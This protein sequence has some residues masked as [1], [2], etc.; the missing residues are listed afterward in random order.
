MKANGELK[1]EKGVPIPPAKQKS[2]GRMAL[3]RAMKKGDSVFVKS[4]N[5][6]NLYTGA[7]M[8]WGKDCYAI[9]KERDGYRIWRT[10]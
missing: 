8:A 4:N 7:K 2:T 1:I 5:A 3:L 10:A 6:S 9:R